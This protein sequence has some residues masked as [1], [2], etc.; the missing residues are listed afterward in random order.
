MKASFQLEK[1]AAQA[2]LRTEMTYARKAYEIA[3]LELMKASQIQHELGLNNP[4]GAHA[5]RSP[6]MR[7]HY[8]LGQYSKA[9]RRL[10]FFL[11]TGVTQL[12]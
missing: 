9:V 2:A 11:W 3:R 12:P 8:L 5:L 10:A 4:D 6:S 7:Y 1:D